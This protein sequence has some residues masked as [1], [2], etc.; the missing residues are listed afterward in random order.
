MLEIIAKPITHPTRSSNAP[1][2]STRR[3]AGGEPGAYGGRRVGPS[4]P[5]Q[6][7]HQ[8][9]QQHDGQPG[10]ATAHQDR[11]ERGREV[12]MAPPAAPPPGRP[13]SG[14]P[15]PPPAPPA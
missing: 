13:D 4:Y 5:D 12:V 10:R 9:G 8:A 14:P 2:A 7:H 1:A 11:V 15:P 3:S 6:Q